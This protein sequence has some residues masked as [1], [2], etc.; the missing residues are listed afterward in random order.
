MLKCQGYEVEPELPAMVPELGV[1]E[2]AFDPDVMLIPKFGAAEMEA[3]N[4]GVTLDHGVDDGTFNH[5]DGDFNPDDGADGAF[6]PDD[7]A[8]TFKPDGTF[9]PD[10]TDNG[11]DG[12]MDN[13]SNVEVEY[14][15][16]LPDWVATG[17][18]VLKLVSLFLSFQH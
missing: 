16:D 5:D 1:A 10:F 12:V 4:H 18:H 7:G 11:F 14:E 2:E 9:D 15:P 13:D 8:F 3:F 6:N 17:L